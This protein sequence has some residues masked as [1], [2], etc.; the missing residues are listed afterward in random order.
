[1]SIGEI[2]DQSAEASNMPNSKTEPPQL[3]LDIF[4]VESKIDDSD[5]PHGYSFGPDCS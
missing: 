4:L 1:M 2:L 3:N 5:L